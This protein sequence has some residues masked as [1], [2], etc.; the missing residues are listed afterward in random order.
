MVVAVASSSCWTWMV[1]AAAA[2]KLKAT[3][4]P[5]LRSSISTLKFK[6]CVASQQQQPHCSSVHNDDLQALLQARLTLTSSI[7]YSPFTASS[8]LQQLSS[9]LQILPSD[10]HHNL[11][12][13]PNR[14][15]LLEVAIYIHLFSLYIYMYMLHKYITFDFEFEPSLFVRLYWI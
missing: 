9:F 13:Q 4:P 15:Q 8:F 7:P 5:S 2:W 11:L 10:L 6:C 3:P 1:A 14:P 12:N